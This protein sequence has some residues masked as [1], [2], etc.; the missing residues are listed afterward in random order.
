MN[1]AIISI[2]IAVFFKN[3]MFCKKDEF[4]KIL[5]IDIPVTLYYQSSI[6]NLIF[7]LNNLFYNS[8]C[9][10][11]YD[12]GIFTGMM[13]MLFIFNF[14]VLIGAKNI[15]QCILFSFLILIYGINTYDYN[16][17]TLHYINDTSIHNIQLYICI[18]FIINLITIVVFAILF[19]KN[20]KN[21]RRHPQYTTKNTKLNDPLYNYND[22]KKE[23]VDC[24]IIDND[25]T[26]GISLN[27]EEEIKNVNEEIDSIL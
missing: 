7:S 24:E 9:S 22:D 19:Y 17:T 5:A 8:G 13:I 20:L 21:S 3:N 26:D 1:I 4:M 12:V 15:F 27:Y 6:I 18:T 2:V 11:I 23:I 14:G 10:L 16:D 25:S